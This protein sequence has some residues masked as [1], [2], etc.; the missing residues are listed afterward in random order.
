MTLG[1]PEAVI[2]WLTARYG[3]KALQ[4]AGR[5]ILGDDQQRVLGRVVSDAIRETV[6]HLTDGRPDCDREYLLIVLMREE[7]PAK[8][9]IDD[10][11]TLNAVVLDWITSLN[12]PGYDGGQGVLDL[13]GIDADELTALLTLEIILGVT[14]DALHGGPLTPIVQYWNFERLLALAEPQGRAV[15]EA[16]RKLETI[17]HMLSE[18]H[19]RPSLAKSLGT[20]GLSTDASQIPR[21]SE[22]HL[23]ARTRLISTGEK[24]LADKSNILC[25]WGGPGVGKTVLARQIARRLAPENAIETIRLGNSRT[26]CMDIAAIALRSGQPAETW[27]EAACLLHLRQILLESRGKRIF[28]VDNVTSADE[29]FAIVPDGAKALTIITSRELLDRQDIAELRVDEFDEH[30][31]MLAVESLLPT[32]DHSKAA[33]LGDILSRHP[34]AIDHVCRYCANIMS[35][36]VDTAIA[37]LQEDP[38]RAFSAMED[39]NSAEPRLIET[40]RNTL[41]SLEGSTT[42]T[43]L[44]AFLWLGSSGLVR[45]EIFLPFLRHLFPGSLG[46]I[47]INAA[48][49]ELERRGLLDE[50]EGALV[51]H[52]LTFD[53]LRR[54]RPQTVTTMLVQFFEFLSEHPHDN[55][56]IA[57]LSKELERGAIAWPETSPEAPNWLLCLDEQ[58]WVKF[59]RRRVNGRKRTEA[60]LYD[61]RPNAVWEFTG[62]SSP[63]R[64]SFSESKKFCQAIRLYNLSADCLYFHDPADVHISEPDSHGHTLVPTLEQDQDGVAQALCGKRWVPQTIRTEGLP[65]CPRCQELRELRSKAPYSK[66][67]LHWEQGKGRPCSF[68]GRSRKEAACLTVVC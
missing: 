32:I 1:L 43:V 53:V 39:G 64:I 40:Y 9:H 67:C 16:Q 27:S 26:F 52:P 31:S 15:E 2:A 46:E 18:L 62:K 21:P 29:A 4:G 25:I 10:M 60:T 33:K 34:L 35:G 5:L 37:A 44:D 59:S 24:L 51:M 45:H 30:E 54:L 55:D 38:I 12:E 61:V 13:N 49:D 42:L 23:V 8:L 57:I 63:A 36:T 68:C 3:D 56:Y 50:R 48:G 66:G 47:Q 22:L 58:T 17:E 11:P 14:Q 6:D 20:V 7:T 41:D 19:A 28:I 65:N